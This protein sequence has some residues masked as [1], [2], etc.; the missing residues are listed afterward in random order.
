[1]NVGFFETF[2]LNN[3]FNIESLNLK[4][5]NYIQLKVTQNMN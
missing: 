1:M 2:Y 3:N 5:N 4:G